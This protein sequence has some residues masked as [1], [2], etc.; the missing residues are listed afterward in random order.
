M[1]RVCMEG[2]NSDEEDSGSAVCLGVRSAPRSFLGTTLMVLTATVTSTSHR[3]VSNGP[4]SLRSAVE[5]LGNLTPS[6]ALSHVVN[7]ERA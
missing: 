3:R 4:C 2:S 5:A 6:L 1:G 7:Y